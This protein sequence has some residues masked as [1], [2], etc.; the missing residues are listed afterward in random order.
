MIWAREGSKDTLVPASLQ[1]G[2]LL[3]VP[4][5]S[6]IS[7]FHIS[8]TSHLGPGHQRGSAKGPRRPEGV[9]E[10]RVQSAF[11]GREGGSVQ[12]G[13]QGEQSVGVSRKWS[14]R[15]SE[16]KSAQGCRCVFLPRMQH[17]NHAK[18]AWPLRCSEPGHSQQP[19]PLV[20]KRTPRG[21]Q[22]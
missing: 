18:L 17:I 2:P 6:P 10:W 9:K 12:N 20:K 21:Q 19:W 11:R 14:A 15:P 4:L 7:P 3:P 5:A 16:D 22:S 8:G 1:L 13:A